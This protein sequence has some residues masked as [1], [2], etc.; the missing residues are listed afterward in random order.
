[1]H[2][3]HRRGLRS[4]RCRESLDPVSLGADQA[5]VLGLL[6]P[7]GRVERRE[8]VIETPFGGPGARDA[9]ELVTREFVELAGQGSRPADEEHRL[10]VLKS[11]MAA[12]AMSALARE[13]YEL[14]G[15]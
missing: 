4:Q 2:E 7:S 3:L 9:F 1:M 11:E 6:E 10:T 12:R 13:V 8:I 14:V 15:V 5:N